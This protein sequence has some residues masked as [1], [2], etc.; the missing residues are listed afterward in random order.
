MQSD[1]LREL[2]AVMARAG[3]AAYVVP[4]GDD[5]MSEYIA[6]RDKRRAFLSGFNGDAGT[7]VI[8]QQMAA[9][10]TDSR[11]F[12]QATK[13]LSAEW[14]L[15]R[16]REPQTPSIEA[17]LNQNIPENSL[18]GIDP[19]LVPKRTATRMS[20]GL[21]EKKNKLQFLRENLVDQ[22]WKN[23]PPY[24]SAPAKVHALKYAG[25]PFEEKLAEVRGKMAA[26]GAATFV[27]SALAEVAWLFNI[28][29]AD[30]PC[31]PF[32]RSYAA[33]TPD[34]AIL[35]ADKDKVPADVL[36][37]FGDKVK[38]QPYDSVV[39][40]VAGEAADKKVWL[41][42]LSCNI[43]LYNA[44]P[45][46]KLIDKPSP[47][48]G[49]KS[50]KNNA[51]LDGIKEAQLRDAAAFVQ[52][53]HW[54]DDVAHD[55]KAQTG[56]TE[57]T[58][59][60]KLEEFRAQQ[61]GY[62][63]PSF[64]TI[65]GTGANGAIIHNEPTHEKC[66]PVDFGAMLLF[67]AGGQYLCGTTDTTRTIHFGTPSAFEKECWTRVLKGHI[68]LASAVFPAG[69]ASPALDAF[70]R[71]SLWQVGLNYAHGTGHGVGAYLGVH[72]GPQGISTSTFYEPM[73]KFQTCT[74]EPGFYKEGAFGIRLE[75]EVVTVEHKSGFLCFEV[76]TFV[77]FDVK[78]LDM[79]LITAEE[80][81]WLNEYHA[82]CLAKVA[83]RLQCGD[84]EWLRQ[85]TQPL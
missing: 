37:H 67:D 16:E 6:D 24:S 30:V 50:L 38:V 64:V 11:F 74:I 9:M 59:V 66:A 21:A 73:Q 71:Q 12:L 58:I 49:M 40:F 23:P 70:A 48:H 1:A 19:A 61:E 4:S 2:R 41:D 68:A 60:D 25:V 53:L 20:S 54:L 34:S 18:V 27:V 3:V 46:V 56:M 72:E 55:T 15:M 8:T 78:L 7:A 85:H 84:L 76:L 82:S 36:T 44:V 80:R 13:Q 35:F 26:E 31:S 69:T 51:E 28:R 39:E 65:A 47:I 10:W 77:P 14:T 75:N 63:G 52:L 81:K 5:H 79:S 22:V 33:I 57:M 17:W 62:A 42:Q 83:P 43:L 29:G 32:L 45:E